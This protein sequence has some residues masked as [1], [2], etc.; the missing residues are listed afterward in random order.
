MSRTAVEAVIRRFLDSDG[1]IIDLG[2]MDITKFPGSGQAAIA[3][4]DIPVCA[5]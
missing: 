4:S 5:K 3:L 1:G 2:V